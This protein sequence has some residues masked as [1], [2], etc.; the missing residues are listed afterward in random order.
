MTTA[1]PRRRLG[2]A[3]EE[4]AAQKLLASGL[5]VVERNWRCREGEVDIVAQ[6]IAPDFVN[7]YMRATWLV[8][9][10]VRTRRGSAFG[11]A[12]ESITPRKARKMR[13]V[14]RRYVQEHAWQGPWRIDVVGV[15]MDG[16]G[17]L[18]AVEHVR[19]AVGD[20]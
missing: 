12:L 14:A 20:E 4:L 3:G 2:M 13:D 7:G 16:Q 1:D 6:E 17:H 8:L 18:L 9:V 5:T 15:Q 19:N 10:E 11:T